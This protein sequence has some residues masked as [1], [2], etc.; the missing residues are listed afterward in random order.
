MHYY[1]TH[2][3]IHTKYKYVI[4]LGSYNVD[5]NNICI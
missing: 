3:S 4:N 1:Y 5:R 2:L